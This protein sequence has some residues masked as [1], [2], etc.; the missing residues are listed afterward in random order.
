MCDVFSNVV[1]IA[2]DDRKK[3]PIP[4]GFDWEN[5]SGSALENLL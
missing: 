2:A 3:L 4:Y 1:N 5:R